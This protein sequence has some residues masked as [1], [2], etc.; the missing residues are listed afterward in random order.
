MLFNHGIA[1][2]QAGD[3]FPD[4]RNGPKDDPIAIGLELSPALMLKGYRQGLFAW[5]ANPVTWWSPDPR[6]II[7]LDGLRVSK[8]LARKIKAQPFQVTMD[9][10]F[11][12]VVEQ[13][14]QPRHR[15]DGVWITQEFRTAFSELHALGYAHSVECWQKENLVG[16]I[17]GVAVN[18]FFS[19]ESMFHTATDA[20]KIALFYLMEHLREA[21]F[22]LFDIQMLTPHTQSLGALEISRDAYLQRLDYA[23]RFEPDLLLPTHERGDKLFLENHA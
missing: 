16:G 10:A 22:Q 13:C 7:P 11:N 23:L 1:I 9:M 4:P 17:F 3:E 14:A 8:R 18:R 12:Q 5:S 6:A 15:G 21:G 2:L 20:S 19:A